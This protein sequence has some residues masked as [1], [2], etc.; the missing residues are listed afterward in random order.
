MAEAQLQQF[1]EKVSQLN[2]FV[3]LSEADPTVRA[4]LAACSS[5]HEVVNLARDLGFAIGRRWGEPDV[6]VGGTAGLLGGKLPPPGQE[7]ATVLLS[8]AHLRLERI[9]SNQACSPEGFWYDQHEHEWVL[10]LQGSARLT[11]E[12]EALPRALCRGDHL[13]IPAGTR[14]RVEATD[15]DPG[16][17]WLALF[18]PADCTTLA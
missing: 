10:L 17:V 15:P 14:H 2:A 3:A 12:G 18:W 13:L 6:P 1:L 11:L 4:A 7:R 16:T 8:N 9:H 5:H